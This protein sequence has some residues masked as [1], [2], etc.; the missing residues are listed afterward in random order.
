MHDAEPG[1]FNILAGLET[2]DRNRFV[3]SEQYQRPDGSCVEFRY[4][5][6]PDGQLIVGAYSPEGAHEQLLAR[7]LDNDEEGLQIFRDNFIRG[8][9]YQPLD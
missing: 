6:K 5:E 7:S 8:L 9:G 2:D 3:S 4:F 1:G